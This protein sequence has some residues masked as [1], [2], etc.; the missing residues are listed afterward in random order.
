MPHRLEIALRPELLDAEGDGIRRKAK[1]YFGLDIYSIR[2]IY[3]VTIDANL[4]EN[5]LKTLQTEIF[6]NPVTQLSSFDPLSIEFDWSIWVG[7]RPGVRDNPGSTAVEAVE[8]LLNIRFA[9]DEGIYTSKRYCLKGTGL[10]FEAV[11]TIAG[12]LLANDIIQQWKIFPVDEWDPANGIGTIIPKVILNHVPKVTT[13]PVSSDLS[14]KQIS[15]ERGLALNPAD[16]PF[17]RSYF[18]DDKVR[19]ERASKGLSDPTDVELEYISQAR[20][21]HCNLQR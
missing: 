12:E 17:I 14:L 2:T 4:S 3:V 1:D 15:E 9:P 21:D 18:T 6:T 16:I 20:S 8:D 11:N 5:Q 13:I 19:A 10:N 7:F